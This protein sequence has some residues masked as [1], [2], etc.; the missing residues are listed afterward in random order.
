MRLHILG[1]CGVFM[2][3]LAQIAKRLGHTVSGSDENIYP[4][5]SAQLTAAGIAIM[6]G[7]AARQLQP[8]PD[9]LIIG[10]ALTRGNPALEYA[11]NERLNYI[12]GPEW[13]YREVLRHRHVL[14]VAGTHGKTTT[15]AILAWILEC[16]GRRPGFLI[17]GVAENFGLSARHTDSDYFV[18]EADEYDTAFF[19]KRAKFIHY[20]PKTLIINNIEF[21]H[22]DIFPDLAAI[23]REFHHLVRTLPQQARLI[24]PAGDEQIRRVLAAGCWSETV[25]FGT[26]SADGADWSLAGANHD[27]SQFAVKRGGVKLAEAKWPLFGRHNAHN[28]LAAIIAADHI[29][30]PAQ[31]AC[32]ALAGFKSVKRRLECVLA[33]G[34]IHLYD[35]FAHHPTAIAMTLGA[36]RRRVGGARIIAV[37]EPRSNTMKMGAH[38][39][40]LPGSL[41]EADRVLI[42]ERADSAWDIAGNMGRMGARS[43]LFQDIEAIV[44]RLLEMRQSGDHIVLMSNGGFGGLREQL[45]EVL[46]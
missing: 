46:S 2:G 22:A 28:A 6:P 21:D 11:L 36:L 7:Y 19:D 26:D 45:I 23:R 25:S 43:E 39:K 9:Q 14:A 5:M 37:L 4:P 41:A 15:S 3:G 35:D 27:Y 18:I 10:N 17:G 40:T 13:L 30:I 24:H 12:S 8:A 32:R 34:G 31:E 20:H 42:R 29:G 16:A 1:I 33:T 38:A 44:A